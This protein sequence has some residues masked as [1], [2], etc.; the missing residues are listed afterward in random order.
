MTQRNVL[1]HLGGESTEKSMKITVLKNYFSSTKHFILPNFC[2][3]IPMTILG[4][5]LTLM[6]FSGG[7]GIN[8]AAK[9]EQIVIFDLT[10]QIM[11]GI[12]L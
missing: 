1:R 4:L 11:W 12:A 2:T 10:N 7:L 9:H 8:V 3:K 6:Q 5:T